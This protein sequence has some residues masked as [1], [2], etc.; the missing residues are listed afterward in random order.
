MMITKMTMMKTDSKILIMTKKQII[1]I[2]NYY[3]NNQHDHDE[4]DPSPLPSLS[5][6]RLTTLSIR[7]TLTAAPP[8]RRPPPLEGHSS[9]TLVAPAATA[10]SKTT[11]PRGCSLTMRAARWPPPPPP[12]PTPRRRRDVVDHV[13][14]RLLAQL[15]HPRG[16]RTVPMLPPP[17][18]LPPPPPATAEAKTT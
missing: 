15:Q 8:P 17:S 18:S 7:M 9:T 2:N 1:I 5:P 13:E 10:H 4:A 16:R 14:F 12:D 3:G 11:D 6:S